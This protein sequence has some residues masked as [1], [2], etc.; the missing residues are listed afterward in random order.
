[1]RT[2]SQTQRTSTKTHEHDVETRAMAVMCWLKGDSYRMIGKQMGLA[3][4]TVRNF[5]LKYQEAGSVKNKPRCGGPQKLMAEDVEMLKHDVL[6]D[7]ESRTMP[8]ADITTK[9]NN[10]LTINVSQT[11][12]RRILKKQGIKCHAAAVKPFVSE[13]NAAKRV[14]WCQERLNWK[15]E[16]WEKVYIYGFIL[17]LHLPFDFSLHLLFV[18]VCI[19]FLLFVLHLFEYLT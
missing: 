19:Y 12:V 14:A 7:R 4:S 8:L 15:I 1:M 16:D 6:E 5:V 17:V 18:F 2:R 13:T 10:M 9:L 11:T 3:Y